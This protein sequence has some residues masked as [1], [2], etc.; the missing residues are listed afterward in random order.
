MQVGS[1]DDGYAVR[2]KL[3]HFLAYCSHPEHA[4]A[5]D[6]PLY[7]FAH[8]DRDREEGR[9]LLQDYAG[10]WVKGSKGRRSGAGGVYAVLSSAGCDASDAPSKLPLLPHRMLDT[11]M[12][13]NMP[14]PPTP[15]ICLPAVPPLFAEDLMRLAG[16]RRRPPYRWFVMGPARSGSS[17]HADPLAT[18]AWNALLAGEL[19]A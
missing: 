13:R 12:H 19:P 3:K 1:D 14:S 2:L 9:A 8:L 10:G 4:P 6:S 7:V 15:V 5:D 16:E 11:H 18:S 17:M